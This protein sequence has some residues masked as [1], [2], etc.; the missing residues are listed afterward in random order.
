MY[1][2]GS[3][4][5]GEFVVPTGIFI[6]YRRDD[7]SGYAG[8]LYDR[9][10]AQY[11]PDRVF[12][13]IDTIR[14]GHDFA[15]DIERALSDSLA[16][17]VLIGRQWESIT[18][19]EGR[20]RLEDPTDFVRLEV[21]AAIR[22]GVIVIPVLVEGASPP[23]AASLPVELQPLA[24]RQAI[25]LSNERWHYDVSRLVLA[26]DEVVEAAAEAPPEE[27]ASADEAAPSVTEEPSA[28]APKEEAP[29]EEAPP[30]VVSDEGGPPEDGTPRVTAVDDGGS[31]TRI[32]RVPTIAAVVVAVMLLVGVG[33]WLASR[34]GPETTSPTG[35]PDTSVPTG[36]PSGTGASGTCPPD[37]PSLP[38]SSGAPLSGTY[39]VTVNLTCM[40]GERGDG[41]EL[42]GE[43]HPSFGTT[44]NGWES[45]DSDLRCG[46]LE[47][48]SDHPRSA[49]YR[50][51]A[52]LSDR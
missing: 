4:S 49:R 20:R 46:R 52:D 22:R 14:P 26:L 25:E 33:G 3:P 48:G 19:A 15:E 50:R 35:G 47:R 42:W 11:G 24:R 2:G 21:A 32:G 39:D 41:N 34:G 40:T 12:M 16:C 8:R 27:E 7:S 36:T 28:E 45:M 6:S 5:G 38:P 23:S 31:K 18:S 30:P 17:I 13:D 10:V 51:R 44:G 37:P 43:G 9:L 1:D 29:K